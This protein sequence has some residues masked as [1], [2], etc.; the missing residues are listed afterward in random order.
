MSSNFSKV[1]NTLIE[2]AE[3]GNTDMQLRLAKHYYEGNGVSF[4]LYNP[5]GRKMREKFRKLFF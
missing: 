1:V 2:I 3:Q 4:D 5:R